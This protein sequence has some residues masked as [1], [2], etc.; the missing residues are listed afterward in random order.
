MGVDLSG[1]VP[2]GRSGS[3]QVSVSKT[4]AVRTL[5][6]T[7]GWVAIDLHELVDFKDLIVEF[8]RR[9]IKLRYRQTALGIAWVVLQPIVA[10]PTRM[11]LPRSVTPSSHHIITPSHIIPRCGEAFL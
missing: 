7:R 6:P 11:A 1:V 4:V 5:R 9:D 2:V 10:A 8:A 3:G